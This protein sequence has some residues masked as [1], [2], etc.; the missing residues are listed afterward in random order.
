MPERIR[1]P[2][3]V[4]VGHIDHGKTSLLDSIRGSAIQAGEQGG[5]TQSIGASIIPLETVRK[6]CGPLLEQLKIELTI[7]GLLF[8]DTPGHEAFSSLRKRGG[9]IADIAILVVD[10]NEGVKPQT[11]EAIAILKQQHTPFLIAANK[12]DLIPGWLPVQGLL[13]PSIA[14]QPAEVQYELERRFYVVAEQVKQEGFETERFDRIK[15]YTKQVSMVPCSA[16][17]LE[18][19]P[20]LVMV[21]AGLSQRYLNQELRTTDGPGKGVILEVKE[22]KGLGTTVDVILHD[23]MLQKDDTIVVGTLNEPAVTKIRALFQPAP[24][25][26]MRDRKSHFLSVESVRA[27]TGVKIAAPH[28]EGAVSGMPVICCSP[29]DVARISAE[30]REEVRGVLIEQGEK[31]VV[32]KADSIG[33]LEALQWMLRQKKFSIRR[34]TIGQVTRKDIVEAQIGIEERP[35]DAVIL[36]FNVELDPQAKQA[37]EESGVKLFTSGIVYTLLQEYEQWLEDL[38]KAK[39]GKQLSQK[40]CKLRILPGYVFRQSNPAICGVEILGGELH[41]GMPL[42]KKA[43]KSLTVVRAIQMDGKSISV[44]Q[45]GKRVAVSLDQIIMGRHLA[46]GEILYSMLSEEQFRK[47]KEHKNLLSHGEIELLKEIAA[48]MREENPVWGI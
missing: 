29:E 21:L 33:S 36:A 18:G 11:R 4:T 48:L 1:Q 9:S 15:D 37:L 38:K 16:R 27:A 46:E 17:T 19:V 42:M 43:G 24:L 14:A 40:P 20:E 45:H 32:A 12:I 2:I 41:T 34:A 44:A 30:I 26:E 8:I 7:P 23:G 47:L 6:M 31:G 5:I 35:Q 25:E 3:V 22:T 39:A 28:L 10:I 13:L